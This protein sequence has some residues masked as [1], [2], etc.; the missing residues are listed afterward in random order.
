MRNSR[1]VLTSKPTL[2]CVRW[3]L[4]NTP[5][6]NIAKECVR[7]P[8]VRLEG[9]CIALLEDRCGAGNYSRVLAT[10]RRD[11]APCSANGFVSTDRR[12]GSVIRGGAIPHPA[13]VIRLQLI[14]A[15]DVALSII[16]GDGV[17]K[18]QHSRNSA[19]NY[20]PEGRRG[21]FYCG[22]GRSTTQRA[23]SDLS[24]KN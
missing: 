8:Y 3:F 17:R 20:L 24:L 21:F 4:L 15:P 23:G 6:A 2:R 19:G 13:P 1:N 16:N 11:A 5:S 14:T 22:T 18:F 12:G 7:L 10:S 9:K